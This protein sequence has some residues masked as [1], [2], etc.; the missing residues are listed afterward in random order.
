MSSLLGV[1]LLAAAGLPLA[2]ALTRA[3]PL[4]LVFAPLAGAAVA[5]AAVVLMIVVGGPMLLWMMPVLLLTGYLAWRLR[6]LPRLAHS[7][8]RD[9]LLLTVPLVPPFLPF[10]QQPASWDAHLIWW[11]HAGYFT[12]GGGF[13]RDAIGSQALAFS[14]QDY[15]PL[16]SA[17]VA[18]V[19]LVLDTRDFYPAAI[20]TGAVTAAATAAVVHAVRSVTANGSA[21]LSWVVAVAVGYSAFSPLWLVPTAGFSDAMCAT[22]FAAG[23]VLLL[24]AREPFGR[25]LPMTLLL[26]SCAA[27]MKNEG[28]SLVLALA[29]V[30]TAKHRRTIRRVGWVWLPVAVAA[31]WSVIARV[32][33]AR[34]DVLAGPRLGELLHGDP[35]TVGRFPLVF[36]TMAGRVDQIVVFAVAAALLGLLLLRDR[37]RAF[38]LPSDLWLWAVAALY[39]VVITVIYLITPMSLQWHLDTSVD[40]VVIAFVVLACASA[41]CWAVTAWGRPTTAESHASVAPASP[42]NTALEQR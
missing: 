9:A 21:L 38:G 5:T 11:L 12:H 19:W 17:A 30:G 39:W 1:A 20:A 34:T 13:A 35:G 28:L 32:F 23:A 24:L 3:L 16:A 22:A 27:L 41:A 8:W 2:F 37:R 40:R 25:M 14:H 42:V 26:L 33:G 10:L 29:V 15:P 4:A 18:L 6:T 7:S 31:A 36:A